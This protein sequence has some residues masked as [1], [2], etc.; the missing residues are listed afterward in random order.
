MEPTLLTD[1]EI[2]SQIVS[3]RDTQLFE[4]L[5]ERHSGRVYNK[6]FSFVHENA[7]AE[8]LTHD[9][10]LKVYL[11]LKSFE[12]RSKF[13]TWIYSITYN[14]CV[15]TINLKKKTTQ[16]LEEYQYDQVSFTEPDDAE[17]FCIQIEVLTKIL[18]TIR[19]EEKSILLMKYQDDFSLQDISDSLGIG[20]SA[21][22]MRL[23]RAKQKVVDLYNAK[24]SH[25]TA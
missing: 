10:F 17:L 21:V 1:E 5:Y 2:V 7:L 14:Y 8:D 4:I 9:I 12:G 19:P 13:S 11:S 20:L 15:D 16:K 24:S 23:T 22:K 6:C 18:N 25:I 3:N